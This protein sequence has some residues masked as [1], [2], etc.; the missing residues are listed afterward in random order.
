MEWGVSIRVLQL[1]SRRA[2]LIAFQSI[3]GR[4]KKRKPSQHKAALTRALECI[5][6]DES[7]YN[8]L[9]K[10]QH[11]EGVVDDFAGAVGHVARVLDDDVLH[12]AGA[13]GLQADGGSARILVA[14]VLDQEWGEL[15]LE[16]AA[17]MI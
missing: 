14:G 4:H 6:V 7:R 8:V 16:V 15:L 17:K 10:V 12:V 2:Q 3:C 13:G 5:F 11:I 1:N 9:L